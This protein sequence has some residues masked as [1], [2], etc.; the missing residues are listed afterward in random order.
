MYAA[1]REGRTVRALRSFG[2]GVKAA[3]IVLVP[4]IIYGVAVWFALGRF[5][6]QAALAVGLVLPIILAVPALIWA[7]V[8][9]GLY[10]VVLDSMR[11]RAIVSRRRAR[12]A[13][14]PAP[15]RVE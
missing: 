3:A 14:E 6:W 2:R 1:I 7:A 4:G 10:Q 8:V 11:R 13:G 9:S 12:I 5:G 15:R